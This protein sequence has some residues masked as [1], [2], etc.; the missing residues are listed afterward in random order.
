[1]EKS[2]EDWRNKAADYLSVPLQSFNEWF[3]AQPEDQKQRV[4]DA[5]VALEVLGNV[6]GAKAPETA[7]GTAPV[8]AAVAGAEAGIAKAAEA[9][10]AV[11]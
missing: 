8:K 6:V 2:P 5:G 3:D 9:G 10:Q 7:A 4:R 11:K 1:M